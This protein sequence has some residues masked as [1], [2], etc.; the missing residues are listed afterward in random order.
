[1]VLT[2]SP[3][4]IVTEPMQKI[5][6]RLSVEDFDRL[7]QMPLENLGMMVLKRHMRR[8]EDPLGPLPAKR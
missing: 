6:T 8:D 1:M 4:V 3:T 5:Q 7:Q 2:G